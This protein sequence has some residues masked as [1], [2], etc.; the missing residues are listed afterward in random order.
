[1]TTLGKMV[2]EVCR[3]KRATQR[4]HKFSQTKWARKLYGDLLD[5]PRNLMWVCA[6]CHASH[7]SP[8]LVHWD[9]MGFCAALGIPPRSKLNKG[10]AVTPAPNDNDEMLCQLVQDRET[11]QWG[12]VTWLNTT[13]RKDAIG[14]LKAAGLKAFGILEDTDANILM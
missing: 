1:M 3:K 11:G 7:A 2:C 9:E 4:H 12:M 13:D 10:K 8:D 5:D 14:I 6:D